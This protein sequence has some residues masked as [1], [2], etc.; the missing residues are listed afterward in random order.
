MT[1]ASSRFCLRIKH[2]NYVLFFRLSFSLLFLVSISMNNLFVFYP[3]KMCMSKHS[4][5]RTFP[6]L[7]FDVIEVTYTRKGFSTIGFK[8]GIG[9]TV[10]ECWDT[11][12]WV[13]NCNRHCTEVFILSIQ[14]IYSKIVCRLILGFLA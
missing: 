12:H 3:H 8:C 9:H 1:E 14:L 13:H 2:W 7:F 6:T 4:R 10:Q 11:M 5:T